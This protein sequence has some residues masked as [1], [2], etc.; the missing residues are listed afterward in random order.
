MGKQASKELFEHYSMVAVEKLKD[1]NM[2][3]LNIDTFKDCKT[4]KDFENYMLN[5]YIAHYGL[6]CTCEDAQDWDFN[7][8]SGHY[9]HCDL[10]LF[11]HIVSRCLDWAE[12]IKLI[13]ANEA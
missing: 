13:S 11:T 3:P 9:H 4:R 1:M 10:W 7:N 6:R 2:K 8:A 5:V 12:E